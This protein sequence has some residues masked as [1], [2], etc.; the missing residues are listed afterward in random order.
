MTF[1]GYRSAEEWAR[2]VPGPSPSSLPEVEAAILHFRQDAANAGG[3]RKSRIAGVALSGGWLGAVLIGLVLALPLIGPTMYWDSGSYSTVN[4]SGSFDYDPDR[5]SLLVPLLYAYLILVLVWSGVDWVR[6]G[7]IRQPFDGY[8]AAYVG[9]SAL[10][11]L[12]FA[13]K[14]DVDITLGQNLESTIMWGC[15][16][17]ALL[18]LLAHTLGSRRS[19]PMGA[20]RG[21]QNFGFELRAQRRELAMILKERGLLDEPDLDASLGKPFGLHLREGGTAGM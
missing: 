6:I 8:V 12:L 17:L 4:R 1:N 10:L 14:V 11:A 7:R 9:G 20:T 5:A 2:G 19:G 3:W 15:A 21:R 18:S 13:H 16:A